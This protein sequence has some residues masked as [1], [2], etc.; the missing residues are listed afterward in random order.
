[1]TDQ[2]QARKVAEEIVEQNAFL[3]NLN[4]IT[5]DAIK[6]DVTTALLQFHQ[7]QESEAVRELVDCLE[8]IFE[9]WINQSG[10][11]FESMGR[12]NP[13]VQAIED[14]IKPAAALIAKHSRKGAQ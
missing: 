2:E 12:D 7:E 4:N 10:R 1:M 5:Q 13:R 8:C 3:R 6:L 14:S 9:T 11:V